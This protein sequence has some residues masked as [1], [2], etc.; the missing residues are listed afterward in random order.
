VLYNSARVARAGT[1]YQGVSNY[2]KF[3]SALSNKLLAVGLKTVDI[4]W[5]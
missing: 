2:P 5:H 4:R 3:D 1:G